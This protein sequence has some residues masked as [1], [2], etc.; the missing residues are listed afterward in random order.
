MY[1]RGQSYRIRFLDLTAIVTS[2]V[3]TSQELLLWS[4]DGTQS[5]W[6]PRSQLLLSSA[7]TSDEETTHYIEG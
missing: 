2:P 1:N 6:G 7:Y 5:V 3:P 4:Q